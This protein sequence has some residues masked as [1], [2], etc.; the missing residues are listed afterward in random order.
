MKKGAIE[1][2]F[3]IGIILYIVFA[4]A[5]WSCSPLGWNGFSRFIYAFLMVVAVLDV[6]E[7]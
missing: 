1:F 3:V 2:I 7:E 6:I 4:F 5:N